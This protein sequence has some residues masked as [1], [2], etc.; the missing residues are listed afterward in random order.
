MAKSIRSQSRATPA[1]K[2]AAPSSA[3]MSAAPTQKLPPA[4]RQWVD[5]TL[6]RMSVE[7]KIGQLLFTT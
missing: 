4:A 1:K 3:K 2:S 5:A 6:R 7:E